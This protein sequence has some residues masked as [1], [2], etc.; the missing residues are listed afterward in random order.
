RWEAIE[1]IAIQY[2]L[3]ESPVEPLNQAVLCGLSRLDKLPFN[4]IFTT[5]FRHRS[6][7]ELRSVVRTYLLGPA[8]PLDQFLQFAD[9]TVRRKTRIHGNRQCFTVEIVDDIQRA[10]GLA[11]AQRIM[12]EIK[13]PC[14]VRTNWAQQWCLYA[15]RKTLLALIA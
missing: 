12:H 1:H 5:P 9:Y 11:T 4:A 14:D 15:R 7:Y 8:P 13:T 10:D 3:P 6:R 2:V